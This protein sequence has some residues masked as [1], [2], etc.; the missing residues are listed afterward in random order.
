MNNVRGGAI[1]ARDEYL[2]CNVAWMKYYK[3][4]QDDDE[5]IAGGNNPEKHECCNFVDVDGLHYGYVQVSGRLDRLG[6]PSS[7]T[8][9]HVEG[10]TVVW[11]A[12]DPD[13]G[14][15]KVVGWYRNARVHRDW[16]KLKRGQSA[17]HDRH[18]INH[19]RIVAPASE[20]RLIHHSKRVVPMPSRRGPSMPE[21]GRGQSNVCYMRDSSGQI[22]PNFHHDAARILRLIRLGPTG[23]NRPTADEVEDEIDHD[24]NL[25]DT[26]RNALI[27]A[28][29]GQGR[30]RA[31]VERIA[32]SRCLLTS[33][34]DHRLLRASHIKPWAEC[35]GHDERLDGH[36]GL[37]LS[38]TADHLFDSG[39]ITFDVEG[40]LVVTSELT[41]KDRKTLGMEAWKPRAKLTPKQQVYMAYHRE[42]VFGKRP[43]KS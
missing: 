14:G 36:N 16:Q 3:G 38:P 42:H 17:L 4:I 26:E 40:K 22:D 33:I 27:K 21:W 6:P 37:L 23:L 24:Q 5:P 10:V 28:R 25:P 8:N 12:T 30:F 29:R 19:Y 18:G 43:R 1:V 31:S 7:R 35:D 39:L 9:D 32:G 15:S 11:T 2:F 41:Q 20:A 34:D 13:N